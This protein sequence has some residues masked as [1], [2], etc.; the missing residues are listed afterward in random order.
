MESFM[1]NYKIIKVREYFQEEF[2]NIEHGTHLITLSIFDGPKYKHV[3]LSP[4][5]AIEIGNELITRANLINQERLKIKAKEN[6]ARG[7]MN[8]INLFFNLF[9]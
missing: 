2:V 1:S 8:H 4:E 7:M 3:S 6:K 5:Q 9:N